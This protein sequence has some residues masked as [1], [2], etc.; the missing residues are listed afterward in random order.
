MNFGKDPNGNVMKKLSPGES[1]A[2]ESGK[3]L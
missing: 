1:G 2:L 3:K